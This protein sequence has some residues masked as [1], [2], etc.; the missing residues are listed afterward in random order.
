MVKE[1]ARQADIWRESLPALIQWV[2][3][4]P[5]DSSPILQHTQL[6]FAPPSPDYSSAHSSHSSSALYPAP[7][8]GEI[9]HPVV[10]AQIRTRFYHVRYTIYRP[11]VYKVLHFPAQTSSDD[12]DKCVLCLKVNFA[13]SLC[14]LTGV[15]N[16]N[17]TLQACCY[18]PIYMAPASEMKQ[19]LPA[20]FT[21]S[22]T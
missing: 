7:F 19:L 16:I 13:L 21:W 15:D 17:R 9:I 3:D 12:I 14:I 5:S 10:R 11:Y 8:P 18:W 4:S 2:D 20:H 1:M 6:T 22:Q